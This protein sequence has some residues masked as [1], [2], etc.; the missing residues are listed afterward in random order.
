MRI[1]AIPIGETMEIPVDSRFDRAAKLGK[2]CSRPTSWFIL[3]T[4]EI[5]MSD[6][7]ARVLRPGD[8]VC[9]HADN[10]DGTGG[11]HGYQRT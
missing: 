10:H 8:N 5:S 2:H 3:C 11:E 6:C 9:D 7:L 4:P 1:L